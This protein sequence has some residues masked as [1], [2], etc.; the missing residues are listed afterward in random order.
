MQESVETI[1]AVYEKARVG[2]RFSAR[3]YDAPHRF[4]IEMQEEA[5]AWLD[6][7]LSNAQREGMRS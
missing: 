3:F 5:F 2:D 7:R 6:E 1:A 4:T